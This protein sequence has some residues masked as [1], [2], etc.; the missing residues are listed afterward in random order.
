MNYLELRQEYED[1]IPDEITKNPFEK[2]MLKNDKPIDL[3]IK[4]NSR[5]LIL[6]SAAINGAQIMNT[7][8]QERRRLHKKQIMSM[9][10]ED[11]M[12]ISE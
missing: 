10:Q 7:S 2:F 3:D 5:L 12:K 8:F 4:N 6:L 1:V 9:K 11:L